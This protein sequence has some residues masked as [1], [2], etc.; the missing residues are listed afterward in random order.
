[1]GGTVI[2]TN[3]CWSVRLSRQGNDKL[4]SWSYLSLQAKHG[5]EVVF[6]MV[7]VPGKPTSA[8][9]GMTIHKQ[10]EVDLSHEQGKLLDPRKKLLGWCLSSLIYN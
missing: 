3:G 7:H 6:I 5:H 10:M 2:G 9:G 4:G 8:G 1:M